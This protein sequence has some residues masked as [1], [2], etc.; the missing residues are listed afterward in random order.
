MHPAQMLRLFPE[1]LPEHKIQFS[2]SLSIGPLITRK[3]GF[4]GADRACINSLQGLMSSAG[5]NTTAAFGGL[6]SFAIGN[7]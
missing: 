3:L 7:L 1:L 5:N 4:L 2:A 6:A